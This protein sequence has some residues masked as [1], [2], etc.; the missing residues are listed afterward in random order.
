ME[1]FY[2][3]LSVF[4]LLLVLSSATLLAQIKVT[5]TVL[6]E[7]GVEL[8]G[9]TV[10]VK[11]TTTGVVTDMDGNYTINVPSAQSVLVF[12]FIG[13]ETQEEVV[14]N[15]SQIS[16]RLQPSIRALQEVVVTGYG[17][18]SKRDITGAVTTVE[19]K[20]LLSIPAT[21][22]AQQLQGRAAG[23][24]IVNDATPGGEATVRIRGFGTI[25]NNNP[26][27]VIDGVPTERQGNLNPEDI[28]SIQVL[29]D[30]SAASIYGSRAANG[31]VI[32]T[33]KR[34]K[35]GKP[36]ITFNTYQGTQRSGNSPDVLNAEELGRYLYLAD[37][38]A[39]KTPGH[40]QYTFGP[41][42][43]VSIPDYV[44][45][46]GAME[47]D[48]STNPSL[49]ALRPGNIYAITRSADTNWWDEVTRSA[50]IQNYQISAS[51]GTESGRYALSA[52]YFNQEGIVKFIGYERY[53]LRA[54]TEFKALNNKLTIGENLSVTF[55]NRKGGF[56]N[57]D[58]QN[59]V[60]GAYKHHPLLPVYDIEGNFAGS[61]GANLGNN[62][63]PFAVLSRQQDNR[64][65]RMR[66]FGNAYAAFDFNENFQL[67]TSLGIDGNTS[68]G[69]FLGR[70][71]PE[72][73]EGNFINSTTARHDYQYQWVW[74]NVL[75]Y[76]KVFKEVHFVDAY[77]GTEAIQEFGEFFEAGRQRFA[78]IT[79]EILSYLDL[80]DAT[81]ATNSGN[82]FRDYSLFSQF[83]K[84]N[85]AYADK[86]LVQVIIRNDASS[87]FL[88]ASRNA[89][90]PAFSLG[91]RL[92]EEAAVKSALPFVSDMKL[93]YGWGKTGNQAIGDYNAFTTY[94]SNIF[95]AG[96]PIDGSLNSP[97]LGFD[98]QR[99]GNP[100]A[101][102]ETTTSN[103]L[104]LDVLL[105]NDK[106][107]FEFDLWQRVTSDMLFTIPITFTA[108]DASAPSSNV[109]QITNKG[110]DIN[111]GY[112]NTT[113]G[114]DFRYS[115]SG[116][117]STYRNK[118]DRL[119]E[120]EDTR[121]FGFGSRVPA[122]TVTQAGLPL[123]SYYGFNVLGIFQSQEE[124]NSHPTYGSYNAPGK[125]KIE[126]VNNDGVITDD[127]RTV[128]GNP[129]PDFTYG[130]NLN[131]GYKSFDLTI[132]G[133]GSVGNDIFNYVRY[134]ADFNTF[135]GN[136]SK[137]ALYDAWQPTNPQA[138]RAQWVAANPN[139]K[140]PI[141]DANDQVS[142]RPSSYFIEDGSY[143]RIR[144]IQLTYSLPASAL[145]KLGFG[146]A[147]VYLQG[148]NLF[149]FTKY[150]G[151]NPEIQTNTDNTLGFDGGYMP[152]S[153]NLLIG[154]NLN[155]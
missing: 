32:I 59:A 79:P 154:L 144:N 31:V 129:H 122:V 88:S 74:S 73:V 56:G 91:W 16:I 51:G 150:S 102:W 99:F 15:R 155:F 96:Y 151:L 7:S 43:E 40:G 45:P 90:F 116:N 119:D 46:S 115:I 98:A 65:M 2:K 22:F 27:Y 135:Q 55:D 130:I 111:L 14:G 140:T 89:I 80:G 93:R 97:T 132:F 103:N 9:V 4:L 30:A 61:R 76:S 39:G 124:A 11:G 54:N 100:N 126:D 141:M 42:G 92:S 109:G 8:P 25:G 12:S 104:G 13:F 133:N 35:V 20:D 146:R 81:T 53:S 28:E 148:Q 101:K 60:S 64:N 147:S 33:T 128:I 139:A 137:S 131:L 69:R 78:F 66:V 94:R 68:R 105:F 120:N 110:I 21:T 50:P 58:E 63:N 44:F 123:S 87:R 149:T 26:L 106:L 152:V 48:P 47:G 70:P 71:Q 117:F 138:P 84:F 19:T 114:G 24:N 3:K 113:M 127:D 136:R 75:S 52:G 121:F 6:D 83:G 118:V 62:F 108:G 57:Q 125:F 142:S 5:G 72:Y 49:Y 77:V 85:Y 1:S 112:R 36:T 134:F 29:K 95:N 67:K 34:G 17:A 145:S 86:Y 153:K 37:I 18:Q 41:N 143:F 38:Y 107:N 10:L 82:V 23:V